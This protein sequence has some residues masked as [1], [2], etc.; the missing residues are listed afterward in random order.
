[1]PLSRKSI[2]IFSAVEA[3]REGQQ[4][5][6]YALL[7]IFQ[8]DFAK[9]N[10]EIFD[11]AKLASEINSQYRLGLTPDVIEQ[12]TPI[13]VDKGWLQKITAE[14]ALSYR[15]T[16]Q[17][18][19]SGTSSEDFK[20][21]AAE[22]GALFRAFVGEISP[23]IQVDTTD[24]NLVDVLVDWLVSLDIYTDEDV[25]K[26][27]RVETQGSKI[28]YIVDAP[29]EKVA[30]E[31]HYLA[32]RF[33]AH[34]IK[35]KSE[36]VP[37]LVE[38]GSVGLITEV[39]RD[40]QRPSEPVKKTDLL[41]YLDGPV[42]LDFIGMSGQAAQENITAILARVKALGGK[43]RIFRLSIDEMQTSACALLQRSSADRTGPTARALQR[44]EVLE[45]F[46]RQVASSPDGILQQYDV[47]IV[48]QTL[49]QFPN[50]HRFFPE[51]EVKDLYSQIRWIDGDVPRWHDASTAALIMRKRAGQQS[52]DLFAV[53]HVLIT[54][55]PFFGPKA[56]RFALDKAFL[57]PGNIGPVVHQ[58]EFATGVWLRAGLGRSDQEIPRK[59]I[60]SA[61]QRVL[62]VSKSLIAKVRETSRDLSD[63]QKSQLELI[64]SEGRATQVLMDKSLGSANIIDSGNVETLIAEMKRAIGEEAYAEADAKLKAERARGRQVAAEQR[65]RL[66]ETEASAAQLQVRS[67]E[68]ERRISEVSAAVVEEANRRNRR[69]RRAG[70]GVFV[71]LFLASQ[72]VAAATNLF[73]GKTA[74]L[75]SVVAIAL[76]TVVQFVN[77][78]RERLFGAAARE[79]DW[80]VLNE[81]ALKFS[82][83]DLDTKVDYRDGVFTLRS[84]SPELA[85][86]PSAD[87]PRDL[88]N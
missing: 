58:R 16:C 50:E 85:E 41:V 82:L 20:K 29:G 53:R 37:F 61:C 42:A 56:R 34:L 79:K 14:P 57:G 49:D 67:S 4:D 24:E 62:A 46:V 73:S 77:K 55:N 47:G 76:A 39:V 31:E 32:A 25:K 72:V 15:V 18:E 28:T 8:P 48:D 2:R 63:A 68:A 88:L 60:L 40:F 75:V 6:R 19:P 65:R 7:P 23:L 12:F 87:S 13:F 10:G 35:T 36:L 74:V 9:F 33:V 5:I 27:R 71:I 64:L 3:L 30:S 11:P 78:I 17:N 69:R 80:L 59:Y 83:Y 22:V 70:Y 81:T 84:D 21:R 1:M 45:A 86:F 43:V 26:L 66:E 44:Q 38:L 52:N 51:N 54:R